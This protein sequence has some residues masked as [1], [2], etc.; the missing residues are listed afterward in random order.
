MVSAPPWTPN[1]DLQ[2]L[3]SGH[4]AGSE[5]KRQYEN[6]RSSPPERS[7][8]RLPVE[9]EDLV[10]LASL[11]RKLNHEQRRLAE[12]KDIRSFDALARPR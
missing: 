8:S 10:V 4:G 2:G 7:F 5:I 12:R 1:H 3:T 6:L 11:L 9:A